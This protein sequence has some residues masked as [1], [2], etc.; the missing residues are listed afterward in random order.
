[1]PE[2]SSKRRRSTFIA[3]CMIDGDTPATTQLAIND[4]WFVVKVDGEMVT[5]EYEA[6]RVSFI[7]PKTG[8]LPE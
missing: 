7:N 3:R 8:R 1:M 6:H 5:R 2:L 4:G